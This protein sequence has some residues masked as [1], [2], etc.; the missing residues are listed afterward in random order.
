MKKKEQKLTYK[1]D[2]IDKL[3]DEK[4]AY[5]KIAERLARE[6]EKF[7]INPQEYDFTTPVIRLARRILKVKSKKRK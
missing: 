4:D 2:W 5:K 7:Y 1:P 3:G 6:V